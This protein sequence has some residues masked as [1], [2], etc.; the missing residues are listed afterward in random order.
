MLLVSRLVDSES[1]QYSTDEL[2]C[3]AMGLFLVCD[4]VFTPDVILIGCEFTGRAD[5]VPITPP[6]L[7]RCPVYRCLAIPSRR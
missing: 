3:D 6:W 4:F 7:S 2:F 5:T 1:V